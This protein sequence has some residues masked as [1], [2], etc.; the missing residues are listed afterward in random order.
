MIS[1]V[2]RVQAYQRKNLCSAEHVRSKTTSPHRLVKRS[3]RASKQGKGASEEVKKQRRA[4]DELMPE[5][6]NSTINREG[7]ST[8]TRKKDQILI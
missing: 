3:K 6:K 2:A 5:P 8:N 1:K 7:R 4:H